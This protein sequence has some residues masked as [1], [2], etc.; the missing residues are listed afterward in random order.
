MPPK[1]SGRGGTLSKPPKGKQS[2]NRYSKP[3]GSSGRST[4][5]SS[6]DEPPPQPQPPPPAPRPKRPHAGGAGP[7]GIS[8]TPKRASTPS[9][10]LV[11]PAAAARTHR[12]S[13][14]EGSQLG[15][16]HLA[17]DLSARPTLPH[18]FA[19][20]TAN[21]SAST[22]AKASTNASTNASANA[23]TNASE[24]GDDGAD[25]GLSLDVEAMEL[26]AEAEAAPARGP[27]SRAGSSVSLASLT[28]AASGEGFEPGPPPPPQQ[29]APL[30][31]SSTS[32]G[33]SVEEHAARVIKSERRR[34][35]QWRRREREKAV[36]AGVKAFS[37]ALERRMLDPDQVL[38][39]EHVL[40]PHALCQPNGRLRF[41][42][43]NA[44]GDSRA[45][46]AATGDREKGESLLEPV[47]QSELLNLSALQAVL[48]R[49]EGL[50]EQ[51]L[52]F[53]EYD[54]RRY[55]KYVNQLGTLGPVEAT[56]RETLMS[57]MTRHHEKLQ[58]KRGRPGE[59]DPER[60]KLYLLST[61][62][63]AQYTADAILSSHR[64]RHHAS[65][66]AL[67]YAVVNELT[68]HGARRIVGGL[69]DL[70][71]EALPRL[72][73]AST[74]TRH[75]Q[76]LHLILQRYFLE[77]VALNGPT[78]LAQDEVSKRRKAYTM[79]TLIGTESSGTTVVELIDMHQLQPDKD[80]HVKTGANIGNGM[81]GSMLK[82]FACDGSDRAVPAS[83]VDFGRGSLA[84]RAV[85]NVQWGLLDTTSTN[86]G[87][88]G[89]CHA[90]LRRHM[91][92]HA[93]HLLYFLMLCL[94]HPANNECAEVMRKAS[95]ARESRLSFR[96]SKT[97]R[98]EASKEVPWTALCFD[99]LAHL[100]NTVPG[101]LEYL[102]VLEG[103]KRKVHFPSLR[104]AP[105]RPP[106]SPR[107]S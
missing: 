1:G 55:A 78:Q 101:V 50:L 94:A 83:E 40:Q 9:P 106:A 31:R 95:G 37:N 61:M 11:T 56:P 47:P 65:K 75:D 49:H 36:R 102:A 24:A 30:R 54:K 77:Q 44:R 67:S 93:D 14:S 19:N 97:V 28:S 81:W 35:A 20:S 86:T 90:V 34:V 69:D 4:P 2:V 52:D 70:P 92:E 17:S 62:S 85:K 38:L 82:L 103:R 68:L 27:P 99:D 8:P 23:S 72:Q 63:K 73:S 32:T 104:H 25:L 16:L 33:S 29:L 64:M 88:F 91:H 53:I 84:R 21:S 13:N 43:V 89:G 71:P 39:M 96:R 12:R 57:L 58:P 22:S 59:G 6:G 98:A 7:S 3:L 26:E 45:R 80:G 48:L 60:Q 66:R 105:R 46:G 18:S 42:F 51:A 5:S 15:S 107:L 41:D 87:K 100:A 74:D 76:E 10:A 79:L